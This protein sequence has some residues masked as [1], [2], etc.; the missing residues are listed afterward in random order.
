M[1]AERS[2]LIEAAIGRSMDLGEEQDDARIGAAAHEM[3]RILSALDR[4]LAPLSSWDAGEPPPG[5]NER[6]MSRIES[7][8]KTISFEQAAALP[9]EAP[10]RRAGGWY[11]SVRDLV[12]AAACLIL[13]VGLFVPGYRGAR[14][15]MERNACQDNMASLYSG[16]AG[17]ARDNGGQLPYAGA[18]SRS[19]W[20]PSGRSGSTVGANARN[21]YLL[22]K[23]GYVKQARVFLCPSRPNAVPLNRRDFR[24]LDNF[25]A[26]A[27]V[28]YSMQNLAGPFRPTMRTDPNMAILGDAN[29]LFDGD[30]VRELL[31]GTINS[32][33]H[34]KRTGQNVLYI[35]G[36][37]IFARKPTV[38]VQGDNIWRAGDLTEYSGTEVPLYATDSFLVP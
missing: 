2:E 31:G 36:R 16:M 11:F 3:E 21:L 34:G 5:M 9:T 19:N 10:A 37:V 12:A 14:A 35:S 29:P 22:L 18:P 1:K 27:N 25:P 6:I 28:S 24:K 8:Q 26:R 17:F 23:H 7:L 4:T 20:L 38:G 30:V 33:A 32:S 15:I 13:T